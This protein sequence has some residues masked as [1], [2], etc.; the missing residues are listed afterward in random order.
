MKTATRFSF[1]ARIFI[2]AFFACAPLP[3]PVQADVAPPEQPPG[4]NIVPGSEFTQVRM[5]AETVYLT[6]LSAPQPGY[7]GQAKTEAI[8]MMRNLGSAQERMQVRFPLTFWN[9]S[10]DG[11]GGYPEIPDIQIQVNGKIV[12][13]QR[14][15]ADFAPPAGGVAFQQMPWAAFDV[16]FPPGQDV[17][18]TVKYTTNGYGYAPYF[19]LRYILE[20]GAGW[21][22]TIGTAEITVK[23]P[24]E[25]NAK[26]V[27]LDE[28]SGFSQ[29][30]PGAQLAG[31]EVRWNFEDL[32]PTS[33]HNIEITLLQTSAW[34][35]VLD[36]IEYVR[37]YPQDGE[38]WGQLGKAYKEAIRFRKGY[39]RTDASG[40]EMY[41][42]SLQAYE[43]ALTFLPQ[44]ALWHYGFAELLWA[45]YYS[46]EAFG[47]GQ[48]HGIP[49]LA[50]ALDELRLSLALDPN[51]QDAKDLASWIG[52]QFPWALSETDKGFDYLILTATPT[53]AL[54]VDTPLPPPPSTTPEPPAPATQ[55]LAPAAPPITPA[56]SPPDLPLCGAV[57][58]PVLAGL[59]WLILK[60]D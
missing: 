18:I 28:G 48:P 4:A 26:N 55:T 3:F 1:W 16:S 22:G 21:K 57:L 9:N 39:L 15:D 19:A 47:T 8:F 36:H 2:L 56:A 54:E 41:Q 30:S 43:K 20:T 52:S 13:T 10:S 11:F 14:I 46:T 45:H 60:R 23:L 31:Q 32:E 17:I 35:D 44:D 51:N 25:A 50:R 38:G 40:E 58:L 42:L 5:L 29:T 49:E 33:E 12:P 24:Y 59:L 7:P 37:K 27:L 34:Q 53:P 6:V